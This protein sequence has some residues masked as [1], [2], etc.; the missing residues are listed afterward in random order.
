MPDHRVASDAFELTHLQSFDVV[1]HHGQF[2]RQNLRWRNWPDVTLLTH[3]VA[4]AAE[5]TLASAAN[6]LP[7]CRSVT[8]YPLSV[9]MT[10]NFTLSPDCTLSSIAGSF[11]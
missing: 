11:T 1:Q 3:R 9:L 10:L 2:A 4:S 8:T 5:T 6:Y 7:D